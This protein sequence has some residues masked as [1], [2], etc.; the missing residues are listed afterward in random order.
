MQ[1]A[2]SIPSSSDSDEIAR[3]VVHG[4]IMS[5]CIGLVPAGTRNSHLPAVVFVAR[6]VHRSSV[7]YLDGL[8]RTIRHAHFFFIYNSL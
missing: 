4:D 3:Q 5:E 7:I 6:S 1:E 8:K 2:E